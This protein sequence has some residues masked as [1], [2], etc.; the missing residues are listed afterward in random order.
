[1]NSNRL[2]FILALFILL[3]SCKTITDQ[4]K[5]QEET[6]KCI[7]EKSTQ[8][9]SKSI[10]DA[11]NNFD[12]I[13]ARKYLECYPNTNYNHE[14]KRNE[15]GEGNLYVKYLNKIINSEL[16]FWI[17]QGEFERAIAIIDEGGK[18]IDDVYKVRINV[19]KSAVDFYCNLKDFN[20]ANF[21]AL[22]T[23][24]N[25]TEDGGNVSGFVDDVA[26]QPILLKRIRKAELLSNKK[27]EEPK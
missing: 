12:F 5:D 8:E 19:I 21:W 13:A 4:V 24:A 10:D 14:G 26:I 22:K 1:M 3:N 6:K 9:K 27:I 23:P 25:K 16:S 11:L 15:F 20:T 17:K 18:T 2:F 7:L